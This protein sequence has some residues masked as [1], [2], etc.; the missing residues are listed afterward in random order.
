L[1]VVVFFAVVFTVVEAAFF[2]GFFFS[3]SSE[4]GAAFRGMFLKMDEVC[5]TGVSGTAAGI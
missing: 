5:Q 3:G 4:T 1:R 2:V